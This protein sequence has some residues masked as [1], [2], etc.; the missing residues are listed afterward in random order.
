MK[1]KKKSQN[2]KDKNSALVDIDMMVQ[3]TLH[4]MTTGA[5][6]F[7]TL[8]SFILHTVYIII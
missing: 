2:E 7:V 1:R 5:K 4:E 6:P 3:C 8:R